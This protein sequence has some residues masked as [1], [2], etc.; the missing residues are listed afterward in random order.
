MKLPI[1]DGQ[2]DRLTVNQT[3]PPKNQHG[4]HINGNNSPEYKI[5]EFGIFFPAMI[6]VMLWKKQ[7]DSMLD[8]I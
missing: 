4:C 5:G 8:L 2:I 7:E 6:H 1:F 3:T